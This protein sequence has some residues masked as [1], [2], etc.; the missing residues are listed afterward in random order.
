MRWRWCDMCQYDRH[1]ENQDRNKECACYAREQTLRAEQYSNVIDELDKRLK[2]TQENE[3]EVRR[4]NEKLEKQ[5]EIA[6]KVLNLYAREDDW[7][8]FHIQLSAIVKNHHLNDLTI[9]T[10]LAT[11]D[12]GKQIPVAIS[13]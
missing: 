3:L 6:T 9:F 1:C 12:V 8:L 7:A 2:K 4:E 5:L 11:S 10:A 13:L